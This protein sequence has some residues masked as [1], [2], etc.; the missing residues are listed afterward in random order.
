MIRR[1]LVALLAML[2]MA[3]AVADGVPMKAVKVNLPDKAQLL[4]VYDPMGAQGDYYSLLQDYQLA[5]KRWGVRINLKVFLDDNSLNAA[6][7]AGEC[8]IASM[9]GMRAREFNLFTGTIDSPGTIENNTEMRELLDV[10]ASPRVASYM[11]NGP[12]EVVGLIP[13]GAGYAFVHDK[14]VN[15]LKQA[16]GKRTAYMSWDKSQV[17]MAHEFAVIPVASDLNHYGSLFNEGDVDIIIAPMVLYK[18]MELHRGIGDDGGIIRRPLFQF[19]IQLIALKNRF[20]EDFGAKSRQ[21][22]H[23]QI[24]KVMAVIRRNES[25]VD[26]RT[27]VSA[28]PA[29][30]VEFNDTMRNLLDRMRTQ[31]L[32]D[33]RMLALMQRIRCKNTPAESDCLKTPE[34]SVGSPSDNLQDSSGNDNSDAPA[35]DAQ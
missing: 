3:S 6:F 17:Q 4:C 5:A 12:Y 18:P 34:P 32:Y 26:I 24:D 19:T 31:G 29:D 16:A 13:V 21:F 1:G 7:K 30:V 25:A 2:G 11:V 15:T 14:T 22:L 10:M 35:S 8:D 27:W 33:G 9:I 28:Q 23:D 20:P